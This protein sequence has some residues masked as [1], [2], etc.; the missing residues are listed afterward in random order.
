MKFVRYGIKVCPGVGNSLDTSGNDWALPV[1]YDDG[2]SV[3]AAPADSKSLRTKSWDVDNI[4]EHVK[5]SSKT[6]NCAQS[7]SG[8]P[9]GKKTPSSLY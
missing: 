5:L 4:C 1:T 2:G 3:I 8:G 9:S 7:A 6:Y